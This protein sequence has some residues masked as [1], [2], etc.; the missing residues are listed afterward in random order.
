MK[1]YKEC[2]IVLKSGILKSYWFSNEFIKDNKMLFDELC[3]IWDEFYSN[4]CCVFGAVI[5]TKTMTI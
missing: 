5:P 3:N 2:F 4:D 1:K